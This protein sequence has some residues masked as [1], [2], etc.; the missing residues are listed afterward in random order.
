MTLDRFPIAAA[1]RDAG[2]GCSSNIGVL[3]SRPNN[4]AHPRERLDICNLEEVG[5]RDEARTA[6]LGEKTRLRYLL[7]SWG[8]GGR[9]TRAG[10]VARTRSHGMDDEIKIV[11]A[12]GVQEG[13]HPPP[14]QLLNVEIRHYPGPTFPSRMGDDSA[15]RR[16]K[17]VTLENC[18][19]L[20]PFGKLPCLERLEIAGPPG[21]KRVGREFFGGTSPAF[22]NLGSLSKI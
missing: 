15:L 22:P 7:L 12:Q 10:A 2:G 4:V 3:G 17:Y 14:Q 16:L 11:A 6:R 18:T 21:V 8:L 13:L 19:K 1:G 5:S 9:G 20:P